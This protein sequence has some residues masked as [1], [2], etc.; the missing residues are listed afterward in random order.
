MSGAE[1]R[2]AEQSA[3]VR[4]ACQWL[5]SDRVAEIAELVGVATEDQLDYYIESTQE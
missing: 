2:G 1:R 4:D 5:E 3:G